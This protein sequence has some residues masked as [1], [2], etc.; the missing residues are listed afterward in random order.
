[1]SFFQKMLAL[2]GR[3][4]VLLVHHDRKKRVCRAYVLGGAVYAHPYL[5]ETRC[6][7]LPGGKVEGECYIHGWEPI[8]PKT[9]A[10]HKSLSRNEAIKRSNAAKVVNLWESQS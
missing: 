7:L 6:K 1:M 9:I 5:P 8:T 10:L 2:M 3:Q 4:Y